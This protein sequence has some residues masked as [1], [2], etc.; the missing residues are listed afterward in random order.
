[1]SNNKEKKVVSF[2]SRF[3]VVQAVVLYITLYITDMIRIALMVTQENDT[4][5]IRYVTIGVVG[6]LSV[7]ILIK[8]SL[9]N[10]TRAEYE[11]V[12]KISKLLPILI[13]VILLL[14]GFYSVSTNMRDIEKE[15]GIEFEDIDEMIAEAEKELEDFEKKFEKEKEY[16]SQSEIKEIE[17]ILKEK[18]NELEEVKESANIDKIKSEAR[19]TWLIT[20]IIY[21][22]AAEVAVY[23]ALNNSE[24]NIIEDI[25]T[26]TIDKGDEIIGGFETNEIEEQQINDE[27]KENTI[28]FDL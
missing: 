5:I 25:E 24:V 14:Y 12:Q 15:Y 23:L 4:D 8:K 19:M 3:L 26:V 2:P 1:M 27:T 13:A 20:S 16:L 22:V 17:E 7:F 9:K 21:L 6:F 11:S 28:K 18:N 10:C